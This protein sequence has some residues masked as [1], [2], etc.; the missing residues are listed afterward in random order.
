MKGKTWDWKENLR[1]LDVYV[2]HAQIQFL[3]LMEFLDITGYGPGGLQ[4]D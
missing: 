3:A 4:H 2:L 1:G